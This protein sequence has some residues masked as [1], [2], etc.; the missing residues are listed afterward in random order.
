MKDA[1]IVGEEIILGAPWRIWIDQ[2][3]HD[4]IKPEVPEGWLSVDAAAT[5]LGM[6]HTDRIAQRPTQRTH[7]RP[8]QPRTRKGLHIQ[9]TRTTWTLRHTPF[10][11]TRD[12]VDQPEL[13]VS[14]RGPAGVRI[15]RGGEPQPAGRDAVLLPPVCTHSL[16]LTHPH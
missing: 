1:F 6:S 4:K 13:L 15:V 5:A 9:E 7:S 11:A 14:L 2:N 10:G 3:L 12:L 8:R 16:R